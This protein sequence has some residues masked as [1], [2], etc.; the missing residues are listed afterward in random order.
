M[1]PV[2]SPDG[3]KVAFCREEKA[4]PTTFVPGQMYVINID[5]SGEK[6]LTNLPL[7]ACPSDWLPD[8]R[9]AFFA[10]GG[11]Y[12]MDMNKEAIQGAPISSGG[13]ARWSPD[14]KRLLFWSDAGGRKAIWTSDGDGGNAKKVVDDNS[15]VEEANWSADGQSIVFASDRAQKGRSQI[16]RVNLNGSGIETVLTDKHLDFFSP[17]SSPNGKSLLVVAY[18]HG[19]REDGMITVVDLGSHNRTVI[20]RGTAPSILWEAH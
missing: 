3:Q 12:I 9:L 5:G 18:E 7:G 2:L 14:G 16:F 4:G 17:V 13:G 15:E 11:T 6:R 19:F 1:Q 20:A 8:G 10:K